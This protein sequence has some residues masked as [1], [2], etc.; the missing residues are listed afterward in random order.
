MRIR[1]SLLLI[2]SLVVLC[3]S[4]IYAQTASSANRKTAVRYLKVSEQY[5]AEK[6]WQAAKSN[7]ETGL[8]YD[9]SIADLWY[10]RAVSSMMSGAPKYQVIPLVVKSL[11]EAQ[12]VDYNRESARVLYADLLCS[13]REFDQSLT[14]LD[15]E[16]FI[17]SADA[18]YIRSKNYYNL[19][20]KDALEK[21][22]AKIDAARRIYPDDKRFAELFFR[23]EY[24]LGGRTEENKKIADSFISL[25]SSYK[26]T[27]P[28]LEIYAALFASSEQ[29]VRMLK[30]FNARSLKSPL[31]AVAALEEKLME[32]TRALDYFYAFA[33]ESIDFVVLKKFASL[34][35]DPE[36]VREFGEYLNA[37]NGTL[38]IDTDGDLTFN[39]KVVYNRGRPQQIFYDEKQ[40]DQDEWTCECDFGVPNKV[41]LTQGNLCIEYGSWPSLSKAVFLAESTDS[42]KLEFNLVSETLFWTPFDI[43]ADTELKSSFSV[44]FFVPKI[45]SVVPEISGE[46]LLASCSSYTMPSKERT[47]SYIKVSALDGVAQLARY[48][49]N[50]VMYAQ[51]YFKGGLP[52]FRSVDM[53]GDGLF[54]TTETYGFSSN[55]RQ[56]FISEQDE[57]QI[58]TNLFGEGDSG[59]GIYVKMIQ[60]DSNGDTIPDFTEEYTEGQGKI[61][62]WD[63]NND[64][65]WDVRY[66]KYPMAQ[67]GTLLEESLFHQPFN[68]AVVTVLLRNGVPVKVSEDGKEFA[69]VKSADFDLYWVGNVGSKKDAE[70]ILKF[71][72]QNTDQGVCTI[73]DGESRRILAVR[74][75]RYIFGELLAEVPVVM[76]KIENE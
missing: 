29:K 61:S 9:D 19:G 5:S 51:T 65:N 37:Y 3:I 16:P 62:S 56:N 52:V 27:S 31:Y 39:L 18:E 53:D 35:S 12:W 32:Q 74:I 38:F 43:V 15:A 30:S 6:N 36:C 54:E 22:R 41:F 42:Y 57:I 45:P 13:T 25:I 7:A 8:A 55:R 21:A 14:V 23:Y 2:F 47:G 66:V 17:Y 58:M 26:N 28:K 73:V 44:D 50:D 64:G 72:N 75:G 24:N 34:L 59:T 70:K 46:Q 67:D 4:A 63:L 69:V 20:T 10:V 11:T 49:A 60:I 71:V 48:Y 76:E 68:N 40:D 33:D 1:K